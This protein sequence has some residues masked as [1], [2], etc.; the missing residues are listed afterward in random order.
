MKRI[1]I[2]LVIGIAITATG[3]TASSWFGHAYGITCR[4]DSNAQMIGCF[5]DDGGY[6]VGI[7][8]YGVAVMKNSRII[9]KRF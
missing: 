3:A 8:R 2:G 6:G 7:S 5:Q 4:K 9:F 1:I